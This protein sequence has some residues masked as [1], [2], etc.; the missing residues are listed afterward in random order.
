MILLMRSLK[1]SDSWRQGS[2][3][4]GT[5]AEEGQGQYFLGT[6]WTVVTGLGD[7]WDQCLL[8]T[9]SGR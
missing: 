7:G 4:V 9:E 6:E 3:V 2:R 1:S 8:E 5:G